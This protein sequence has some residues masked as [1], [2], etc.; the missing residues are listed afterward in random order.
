MLPLEYVIAGCC[1]AGLLGIWVGRW[2]RALLVGWGFVRQGIP[3]FA[4][5]NTHL[6]EMLVVKGI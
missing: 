4:G 2:C 1:A 3:A 5:S 6:F